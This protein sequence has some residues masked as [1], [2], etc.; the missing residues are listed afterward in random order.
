LKLADPSPPG[1]TVAEKSELRHTAVRD[2]LAT[3]SRETVI[4]HLDSLNI[5]WGNVRR[6]EDIR[7]QVTAKHRRAVVQID[8]RAGGTR[9]IVQSPYRFSAA[10]SGVRRPAPWKGEHNDEVLEE[11]L[12][13]DAAGRQRWAGVLVRSEART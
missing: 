11:W 12:G 2:A 3:L 5:A 6:S 9:P 10:E 13:L 1:A 4:A 7:E 8:D